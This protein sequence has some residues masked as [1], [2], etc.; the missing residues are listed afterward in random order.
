MQFTSSRWNTACCGASIL[1]VGSPPDGCVT[2][3]MVPD[4]HRR[5]LVLSICQAFAPFCFLSRLPLRLKSMAPAL[6]LTQPVLPAGRRQGPSCAHVGLMPLPIK[7]L[8]SSPLQHAHS[9]PFLRCRISTLS[10]SSCS[11]Q[12][13]RPSAGGSRS[14]A[15]YR[16]SCSSQ[17]HLASLTHASGIPL[18]TCHSSY[19][20]ARRPHLLITSLRKTLC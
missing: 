12:P 18:T 11:Y 8:K 19:K 14:R 17:A 4:R 15:G 1:K 2:F 10:H 6:C 13:A 16:F 9:A 7:V 3:R 20:A 5:V